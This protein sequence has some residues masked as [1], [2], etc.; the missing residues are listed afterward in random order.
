MLSNKMTRLI[1][2]GTCVGLGL[3]GCSS[4]TSPGTP[5]GAAGWS[6]ARHGWISPTAKKEKLLYVSDYTESIILIYQQGHA[7]NGPIG[8]IVKGVSSPQG[9]AVDKSG[10]LYVANEGNNT[11]TEYPVGASDPTVT[12]STDISKPLDVSVD[13]T[14]ILYITEGSASTI[15]EFKPGSMSPDATVSL[16]HPSDATNAKNDNLYVTY[17]ESSAGHVA[18]CKPLATTCADLG[19][20]GV[21]GA[22]GIAI[23]LHGNLLVGDFYK[24]VI[25][26]YKRGKT[27]PFRT[28]SVTN[29]QPSKLALDT[30]GATLYMADPANF[31]VRLFDYK[32]RSQESDFTYGSADELEGVALFP[33]QKPGK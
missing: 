17:N 25:D 22:Q 1:A 2:I 30:K 10:T 3:A 31:A 14:G 12:L 9:I 5:T 27:T 13:S 8:E 19:I 26:I 7:G 16:T 24:E 21:E 4:D 6:A 33:G 15:L 28:I 18:E 23:D 32:T 29:E 20:S 11:V